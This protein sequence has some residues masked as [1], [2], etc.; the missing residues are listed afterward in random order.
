[1]P[2]GFYYFLPVL[3]HH[4]IIFLPP[5]GTMWDMWV[6]V[7]LPPVGYSEG[8]PAIQVSPPLSS[9]SPPLPSGTFPNPR[10]SGP[11]FWRHIGAQSTSCSSSPG[12]LCSPPSLG[13]AHGVCWYKSSG[14]SFFFFKQ[15]SEVPGYESLEPEG[16]GPVSFPTIL[17]PCPES[18]NE[19]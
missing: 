2:T 16:Q 10:V 5:N 12:D 15:K 7:P 8:L 6:A 3:C 18:L 13:T 1:M 9:P 14:F 19:S 11:V 17:W 4:Q